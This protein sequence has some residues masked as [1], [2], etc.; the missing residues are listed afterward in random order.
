MKRDSSA[1]H[2]CILKMSIYVFDL[3]EVRFAIL[4]K[5]VLHVASLPDGTGL[6]KIRFSHKVGTVSTIKRID[7]LLLK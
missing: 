7:F 1:L 3:F 2:L 4:L 6:H 5:N